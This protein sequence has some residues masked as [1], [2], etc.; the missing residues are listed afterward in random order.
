REP[1]ALPLPATF[2]I[3]IGQ[4]LARQNESGVQ[5]RLY[6]DFPWR[7]WRSDGGPHDD[8]ERD[9]LAQLRER[10]DEPYYRFEELQGKPVLRYAIARRM[11]KDCLACHNHLP[12]SPKKTWREGDVRGVLEIIR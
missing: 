3:D 10:P 12:E 8:F 5:I 9:A 2:T 4:H 7:K 11:S 6:S 1:G